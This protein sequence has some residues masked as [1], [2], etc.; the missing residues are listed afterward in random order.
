MSN[1][2]IAQMGLALNGVVVILL[3]ILIITVQKI[4]SHMTTILEKMEKQDMA[5]AVPV[6]SESADIS[7]EELAA[8]LSVIA[9]LVPKERE[10][11]LRLR[12]VK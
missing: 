2:L 8:V 10:S 7:N 5:K 1:D 11:S 4:A 9:N 3:I 12:R 6:I